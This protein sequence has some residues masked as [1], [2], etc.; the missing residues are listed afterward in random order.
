[1]EYVQERIATLHDYDGAV[2]SAPVDRAAVIVPLTARDYGSAATEAVFNTLASINPERVIVPLRAEPSIVNDVSQWLHSFDI[3]ITVLWC[4]APEITDILASNGLNGETGKGRD[5]WLALGLASK[6]DYVVI[7]DADATTYDKTTVPRLL[8]PL[9]LDYEFSKAYYSRIENN[10]LYG[11]LFRLFITPLVRALRDQQ[12]RTADILSYIDAFRYALSG[13]F[14]MT[15]ELAKSLQIPRGWGLEIGTLGDAFSHAGFAGT[16]QVDLGIHQ[17]EHRPVEGD[18]G[19]GNMAHD[20]G[21]TFYSV[22]ESHDILPEYEQL[23]E[24]Y[25]RC[26]QT[27]I[28]Q[29]A[30]DAA[31]NGFSY[32]VE[33]ERQQVSLYA[34]AITPPRE[35]T[36]LP[37]WSNISLSPDEILE[38]SRNG[39][40]TSQSRAQH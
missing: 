9:S 19:L 17:H 39:L 15:G 35:D 13:E 1:M 8:F 5:V 36:R 24:Q 14:A 34:K 3:P 12:S 25:K 32:D 4:T 23:R 40:A 30:A 16:A 28:E 29:Y 11:R 33:Q 6:S 10:Q 18:E 38:R 22:L 2:P 20:V 26:A 31:F 7:H 27:L 21:E 37:A